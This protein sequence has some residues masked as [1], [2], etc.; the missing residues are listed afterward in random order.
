MDILLIYNLVIY[1]ILRCLGFGI[2]LDFY[3]NTR[4]SRFK[5]A[6]IGWGL[7]VLASVLSTLSGFISNYLFIDLFLFLNSFFVALATIFYIWTI[8]TYFLDV[9]DKPF[10]IALISLTVVL[11]VSYIAFNYSTAINLAVIIVS[12]ILLS[13]YIV[14]ILNWKKFKEN[15]GVARKWYYM[16][17]ISL[18]FYIIISIY[19][20]SQG[21][22]YYGIYSTVNVILIIL[23]YVPS[24]I[25]YII[26]IVLIIHVEYNYS[27]KQRFELKDKYSH[28]LGNILQFITGYIDLTSQKDNLENKNKLE[29][30]NMF[31]NKCKE[32][33]DLIQEIREL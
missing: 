13:V 18:A 23:N 2:S 27:H 8:F 12:F 1:L 16:F 33:A 29:L 19:I 6:L 26:L 9:P 24:I 5:L 31:T 14:P 21:L 3:Y 30:S 7:W 25:Y 22:G 15:M 4:Q 28:D 32:A 10:I 20:S 17:L 11:L